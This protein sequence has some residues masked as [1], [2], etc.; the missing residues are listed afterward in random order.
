LVADYQPDQ[1]WLVY[2]DDFEQLD[3][4]IADALAV[5]LP[6]MEFHSAMAGDRDAVLRS[7]ALHGGIVVA[8][9]CLDEGIDIPVCDHALI[10]AS[11]TVDREYVQRRGRVLRVAE[12]KP[13]A[14]IHDLLLINH[15][16]GVLARSE[17]VRALEF[18]RLARNPGARANLQLRLALSPDV[19][20]L[21]GLDYTEEDDEDD[22]E[23]LDETHGRIR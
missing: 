16:G 5:G 9:R 14:T 6:V 19:E 21:P 4:L 15:E 12:D 22:Q 11:S 3:R 17:A 2:C 13:S 1:R 23:L 10:L 20:R 8:I 18:A 7:L